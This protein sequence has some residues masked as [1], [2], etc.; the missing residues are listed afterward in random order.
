MRSR[1]RVT[2][3]SHTSHRIFTAVLAIFHRFEN[4]LSRIRSVRPNI[5]TLRA[6]EVS[7]VAGGNE[8]AVS[9]AESREPCIV[10]AD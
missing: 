1:E 8:P 5:E 3:V 4:E 7:I 6:A 2:H 9:K 10:I